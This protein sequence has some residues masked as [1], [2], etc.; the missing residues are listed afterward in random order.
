MKIKN[1]NHFRPVLYWHDL[2]EAEQRENASAYDGVKDSSFFRY[3][4]QV[5]D[6]GE[7]LSARGNGAHELVNDWDGYHNDS[8]FSAVL[9]KYSECQDFVKVGLALS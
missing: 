6:L 3:R 7:F 8:Y 4:G 9:V 5:Y 1:N 2:T